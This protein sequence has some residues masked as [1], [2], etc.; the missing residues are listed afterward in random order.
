MSIRYINV[1]VFMIWLST[2]HNSRHINIENILHHVKR[3]YRNI[4]LQ[5]YI[6]RTNFGGN[7]I[8]GNVSSVWQMWRVKAQILRRFSA[9]EHDTYMTI[10]VSA[11]LWN[12]SFPK[13]ISVYLYT[14]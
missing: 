11:L 1:A 2:Y 9:Q 8:T 13:Y 10:P 14:I 12:L 6:K 7:C 5:V 3:V 4:N